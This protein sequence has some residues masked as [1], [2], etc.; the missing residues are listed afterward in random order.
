MNMFQL[1]LSRVSQI[2]C[3]I[4]IITHHCFIKKIFGALL[5]VVA[6]R[7]T[8]AYEYSVANNQRRRRRR[9]FDVAL[10]FITHRTL[11][12]VRYHSRVRAV[13]S[14]VDYNL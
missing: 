6:S 11:K 13:D 5:F 10:F 14:I 12:V 2:C 1:V 8:N 3:F 7:H 9:A 4:S